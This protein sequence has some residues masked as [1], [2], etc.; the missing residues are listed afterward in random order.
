MPL[1]LKA[2]SKW[3]SILALI[4]LLIT[5]VKSLIALVGRFMFAV[6]AAIV[7]AFIVLFLGVAIAVFRAISK[8]K[9]Q[10]SE[11]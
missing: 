8:N 2:A 5:L 9:K 7:L 10:K 6:K 11:S 4:A 1:W 3:G